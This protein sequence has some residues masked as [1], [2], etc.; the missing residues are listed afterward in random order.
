MENLTGREFGPYRI[1]EPLG[2]GG[3]ASV[4]KGYQA[5]MDRYVALKVLPRHFAN[6]AEFVARFEQE[7][8]VLARLRHPHILPVHDYGHVDSFTYLVM[9]FI[10]SGTL[11]NVLNKDPLPLTNIER[12]ISQVGDAL[13]YAHTQGII[14][15]DVKPSNVLV[16]ERGN[17]MLVDFG[18][19]KIVEGSNNLTQTGGILGT[20]AYMAPEQGRGGAVDARI[21]I[22]A[23]GVILYEMA[24][25]R[26]PFK[27]ETPIA[28]MVKHLNDPL[29]PPHA[30][31]PKLPSQVEQVILKAMAKNPEDRFATA[32]D[33][34]RALKTAVAAAARQE[35]ENDSTHYS[36]KPESSTLTAEAGPATP[37]LSAS[38]KSNQP[39]YLW[40]I[41]VMGGL[42]LLLI[43]AVC[44]LTAFG[45]SVFQ[46]AAVEPTAAANSNAPALE[47][48]QITATAAVDA[49][50]TTV[51]VEAT[52]QM[53]DITTPSYTENEEV[54]TAG[55]P[56]VDD[57]PPATEEPYAPPTNQP[58]PEQLPT[59]T[60]TPTDSS[61]AT[62]TATPTP[63]LVNIVFSFG[64]EGIGPGQFSDARSIAVDNTTGNIYVGEYTGGRIQVFD[65]EGKFKTQIMVDPEMPLR[66]MDVDRNGNL[67]VVQS[68]VISKY[69]NQSGELIEELPFEAGWGFDDVVVTADGGLVAPWSYDIVRMNAGG[70]PTL[71]IPNAVE[72]QTGDSELD[73]RLAVDGPGNIYAL[74]TFNNAVLKFGPDG[75]FIDLF[76]GGDGSGA[77]DAPMAIA[78]DGQGRVFVSELVG[79]VK[80]FDSGGQYISAFNVQGMGMRFNDHGEMFVAAR[81]K[82]LKYQFN[83]P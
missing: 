1:V 9:P 74:G 46:S 18:I 47:P 30:L 72:A 71:T 6:D 82:V 35:A 66:G 50:T 61:T 83:L 79:P 45:L 75:K 16:D 64:S 8:K 19:A 38:G 43:L 55:P 76:G 21:D 15:R 67:F 51:T 58:T 44:G 77:L 39:Q 22:Y 34:V 26:V 25:G 80:I 24:T 60:P 10:E 4:Y 5:N 33:M 23:L 48:V 12:I 73:M 81:T 32:G 62:P 41:G 11:I 14:H 27:A 53:G 57:L 3:M 56:V 2:E 17:C 36:T 31:N 7:A 29:P 63:G 52:T 28:V 54:A 65:A 20:P 42:G 70:Q 13:D 49:A 68:G 78:V 59:A 40:L 37:A 69:N